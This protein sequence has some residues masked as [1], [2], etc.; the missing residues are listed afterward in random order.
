L[1]LPG[2]LLYG[3]GAKES[4]SQKAA[5]QSS[6]DWPVLMGNPSIKPKNSLMDDPSALFLLGGPAMNYLDTLYYPALIT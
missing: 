3:S 2:F 6:E 4:L 1:A 5:H